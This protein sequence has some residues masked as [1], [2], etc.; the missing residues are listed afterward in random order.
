MIYA[1][2]Q[3]TLGAG[4]FLL[5]QRQ[6]AKQLREQRNQ[7]KEQKRRDLEML[8]L[9]F[10]TAKQEARH[11]ADVSDAGVDFAEGLVSDDFNAQIEA[12]RLGQGNELAGWNASAM[13]MDASEADALSQAAASGIR[14][15]S[16]MDDA[17]DLQS[18]VNASQLQLAQD[19]S[20]AAADAQLRSAVA[21]LDESAFG[22]QENRDAAN[23]LR[24][25]YESG[26]SQWQ[27]WQKNRDNRA[28]EYDQKIKQINKAI[29]QAD[30]PWSNFLGTLGALHGV[31][32]LQSGMQVDTYIS[33]LTGGT[34][35]TTW[36]RLFGG[37]AT[38]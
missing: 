5:G 36:E 19:S 10:T 20:R 6:T 26:G 28:W 2:V 33:D 16:S 22:F 30:D 35:K 15:G 7:L 31:Q 13:A 17:I 1:G 38:A 24:D 37:E 29:E 32:G 3:N 8:D 23:H 4:S 25:S 27:L 12:I 21:G 14:S 11:N 9:Q 18:A 34:Y